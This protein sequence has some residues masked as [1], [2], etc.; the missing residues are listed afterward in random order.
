MAEE[1]P[2]QEELVE[3]GLA[4]ER[5]AAGQAVVA[6]E[7]ERGE[8][9]AVADESAEPGREGFERRDDRVADRVAPRRRRPTSPSRS[10]YGVYW[11]MTLMTWRAGRRAVDERR[12]DE[13]RDRRLEDRRLGDAAVLRGVERPLDRVDPWRD[14]DPAAEQ[15]LVVAGRGGEPRQAG[16]A[17]G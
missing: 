2:P 11:A 8:D 14:D 15:R 13:G 6:L 1:R 7:I 10:A 4:V 3:P 5:V 9:L 16:R 17:R 12:V